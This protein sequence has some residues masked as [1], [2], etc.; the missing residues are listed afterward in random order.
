MSSRDGAPEGGQQNSSEGTRNRLRLRRNVD[1]VYFPAS[2]GLTIADV[3][4]RQINHRRFDQA[5]RTVTEHRVGNPH[6]TPI[7]PPAQRLENDGAP[8][9]SGGGS[10]NMA[11]NRS[12]SGI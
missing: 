5:A 6:Q 7:A 10:A 8:G 3:D 1:H 11:P 4:Y 9:E 12:A 2:P